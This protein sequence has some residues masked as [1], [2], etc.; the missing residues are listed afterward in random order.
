MTTATTTGTGW[1]LCSRTG[2]EHNPVRYTI[3]PITVTTSG[4]TPQAKGSSVMC[5]DCNVY[6]GE[7]VVQDEPYHTDKLNSDIQ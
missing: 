3:M 2:R 4:S 1:G 5:R 6:L 7:V